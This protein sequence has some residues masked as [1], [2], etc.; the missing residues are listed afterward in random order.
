MELSKDVY[1][2]REAPPGESPHYITALST[3]T[4]GV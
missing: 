2:V 4:R 3:V 1:L